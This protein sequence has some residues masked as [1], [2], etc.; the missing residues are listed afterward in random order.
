[1]G[2]RRRRERL[3]RESLLRIPLVERAFSHPAIR[4]R[5]LAIDRTWGYQNIVTSNHVGFVPFTQA[6]F[7]GAVSRTASWS[8]RRRASGRPLNDDDHL[9]GEVF[10]CVHDFL[11]AWSLATIREVAP[12][13]SLRPRMSTAEREDLAYAHLVT[14]AV[15]TVGLDYWYLSVVDPNDV[16]PLGTRKFPL[17]VSYEERHLREYRRARPRLVVQR[18]AFL[19][20]LVEVYCDGVFRGFDREDIVRSPRLKIWL[21]KEISYGQRQRRYIRE[22]LNFLTGPPLDT[23]DPG[24][25]VLARPGWARELVS[26]LSARLWRLVK[27]DVDE[28]PEVRSDLPWDAARPAAFDPRFINLRALPPGEL[29]RVATPI[30][31]AA[32]RE[33]VC[34]QY[35]SSFERAHFDHAHVPA[36]SRARAAYDLPALAA[37]LEGVP[38]VQ[39]SK[40]EPASLFLLG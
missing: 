5:P 29:L 1:V 11:H 28:A 20:E 18:P 16:C 10:T 25:A 24:R 35:V 39:R 23:N 26:L 34:D 19:A 38:R 3:H 32:L 31:D 15:A 13:L 30:T 22:W 4:P 9:V 6:V 7:Y 33:L 17:T 8:R 37:L 21:A 2:V 36:L 12:E 27:D 40:D 14:E